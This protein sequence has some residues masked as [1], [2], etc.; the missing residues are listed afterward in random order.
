MIANSNS[1]LVAKLGCDWL[2]IFAL[3]SCDWLIVAILSCD[4][5]KV[6]I[7]ICDWLQA[8]K[9]QFMSNFQSA[10]SEDAGFN[11]NSKIIQQE[12]PPP[13]GTA[14]RKKSRWE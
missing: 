5:L 11:P 10:Q 7:L 12:E 8:Y 13:P 6:A 14:R 1:L 3:L 9:R 4:W 2:S